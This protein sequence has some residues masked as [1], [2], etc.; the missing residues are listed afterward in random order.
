V[1]LGTAIIGALGV[2]FYVLNAEGDD[3][4]KA[5]AASGNRARMTTDR[6]ETRELDDGPVVSLERPS[7]TAVTASVQ[8]TQKE[9]PS[10]VPGADPDEEDALARDVAVATDLE[11]RV[12]TGGPPSPRTRTAETTIRSAFRSAG[13]PAGTNLLSMECRGDSCQV[14]MQAKDFRSYKKSIEHMFLDPATSV[15]VDMN[16]L[17]PSQEALPDGSYKSTFYLV[18]PDYI[19]P[20]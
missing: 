9:R 6:E 5:L 2:G 20:I 1:L 11:A 14:A 13:L 16:I 12:K 17:F 18:P 10:N 3:T 7:E 4:P 15:A 8:T 19:P